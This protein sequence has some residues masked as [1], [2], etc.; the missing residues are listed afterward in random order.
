MYLLRNLEKAVV[1]IYNKL[2]FIR[3]IHFVPLENVVPCDRCAN[4][5]TYFIVLKSKIS[6]AKRKKKG[7]IVKR[8]SR[9][10]LRAAIA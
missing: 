4:E 2:T 5:R 8:I 3:K 6:L 10:F 9:M 7:N 1:R